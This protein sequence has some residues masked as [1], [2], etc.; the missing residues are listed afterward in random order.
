VTT[1]YRCLLNRAPEHGG[2]LFQRNSLASLDAAGDS[3]VARDGLIGNFI[4]SAEFKLLYGTP[5]HSEF[6]RIIYRQCIGR[7]PAPAEVDWQVSMMTGANAQV[8]MARNTLLTPEVL[9][10]FEAGTV[11]LLMYHALLL[12]E[13]HPADIASVQD[14]MGRGKTLGQ[15]LGEIVASAEFQSLY[16]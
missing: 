3:A 9:N 8:V 16:K 11:A 15:V 1:L 2:W 6:V 13:G 12:R 10:R 4:N 7:E 14:A 5:N